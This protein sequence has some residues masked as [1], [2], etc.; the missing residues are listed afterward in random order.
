MK[1]DLILV[2]NCGSSSIKFTVIEPMANTISISGLIQEIDS[3]EAFGVKHRPVSDTFKLP[4]IDYETALQKITEIIYAEKG[5]AENIIAVGHRVVHGGEKFTESVVITNEVLKAIKD[6][7]D[8]APLHNPA[9]ILGIE[10]AIKAFPDVKQ[11]AVF[12][13][14]FHQT[15]PKHAYIYPIPYELYKKHQ[16]RRYG[17][18]GTS[19]RFVSS[20]AAKILGKDIGKLALITAHL[21]NGCSACAILNGKSADTSMGLTPLEGLVMGTRSG[22]VDPSLHQHLADKLGL[23]L[24]E[25]TKLLNKKSGL[26]G[27]SGTASDM[28]TIEKNSAAGD[29]QATLALEIFC[30]RLAKYISAL[31]VPLGKLDALI[32]TGGIGENSKLVREKT[33]GWLKFLNFSLDPKFNDTHGKEN[34]GII[35]DTSS[36]IAMVILTNEEL[37]IA[38]DALGSITSAVIN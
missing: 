25:I 26:L 33:L 2:L 18:H 32:F 20:E 1:K 37:L 15:M 6:C 30:Y 31:V 4:N 36:T 5:I 10:Q 8:L 38:R 22:D 35:T 14:A 24:N 11:V 27:I 9:N 34:R 28:R 29:K 16:I 7:V 3:P 21:G 19:H 12:D 13:T 23:S 17:F